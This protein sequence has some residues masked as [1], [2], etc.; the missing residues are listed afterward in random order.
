MSKQ[1]RKSVS[2]LLVFVLVMQIFAVTS[3]HAD[4][5]DVGDGKITVQAGANKIKLSWTESSHRV[6]C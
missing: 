1:V 5:L 3:V 4:G 2:V 6:K